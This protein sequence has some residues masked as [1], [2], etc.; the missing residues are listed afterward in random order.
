V[1]T[2]VSSELER[3]QQSWAALDETLGGLSE[4]QLT[5]IMKDRWSLK[6]HLAHI[7]LAEQY[8]AA[9]LDERALH[10]PFG[11]DPDT[12][13]RSSDDEINELGYQRTRP[14]SVGQVQQLRRQSHQALLDTLARH[15]DA[16]LQKP[17]APYGSAPT[18]MTLLDILRGNTYVHY[19]THRGWIEAMLAQ[20]ESTSI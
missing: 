1:T 12:L 20:A 15:V 18:G 9:A 11:T 5:G 3:I 10:E 4:E 19:D 14:L 17:F 7:A 2:L 6:D 13:M 16:D 8:C